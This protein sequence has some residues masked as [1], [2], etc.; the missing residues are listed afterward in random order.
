MN[1]S[2]YDLEETSSAAINA[3]LSRYYSISGSMLWAL[4]VV[5]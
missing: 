5:L 2:Y 3:F 1:P 4:G